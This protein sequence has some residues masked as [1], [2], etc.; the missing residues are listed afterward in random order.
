MDQWASV[1]T[2]EAW[3][4]VDGLPRPRIVDRTPLSRL[5]SGDLLLLAD[6][7]SRGLEVDFGFLSSHRQIGPDGDRA[8]GRG[9]PS[10]RNLRADDG[11]R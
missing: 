9:T 3:W 8:K 10:R 4:Q 11:I 7:Y 2:T 5:L 1:N 6:E